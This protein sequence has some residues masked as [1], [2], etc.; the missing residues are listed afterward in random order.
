MDAHINL[1]ANRRMQKNDNRHLGNSLACAKQPRNPADAE[2]RGG[3]INTFSNDVTMAER[4][5]LNSPKG[6]ST[7]Y[8]GNGLAPIS[9]RFIYSSQSDLFIILLSQASPEL[10]QIH[11][12][13]FLPLQ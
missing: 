13:I 5:L 6:F 11:R 1:F 12:S 4:K 7:G 8:P 3:F 9:L 2:L 10:F